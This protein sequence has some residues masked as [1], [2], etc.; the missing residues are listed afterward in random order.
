M[1]EAGTKLEHWVKQCYMWI[2]EAPGRIGALAP[3]LNV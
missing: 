1:V 2:T 3:P